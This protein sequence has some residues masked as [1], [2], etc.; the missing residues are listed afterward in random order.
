M[1]SR[2]KKDLIDCELGREKKQSILSHLIDFFFSFLICLPV[3]QK[4]YSPVWL[5]LVMK[6]TFI[7]YFHLIDGILMS[8][9]P[10]VWNSSRKKWFNNCHLKFQY[11]QK[12]AMSYESCSLHPCMLSC[13]N[14]VWLFA[15]LW[16]VA[17]Q[18]P[19]SMGFSR[20]EY[21]SGLPCP[22]PGDL[23]NPGNELVSL[24]CP[25]LAG[26][27]ST[28]ST[29]WKALPS[30]LWHIKYQWATLTG[31]AV[32]INNTKSADYVQFPMY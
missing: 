17:H 7:F 22:P 29:T 13:F 19:L 32:E 24:S 16:T 31:A 14:H 3:G 9:S 15:T 8:S 25:A 20:Q 30:P 23:P 11:N 10:L 28:T 4:L 27:F 1:V 6:K 2:R 12:H 18:A 5:L 21:W 26:R